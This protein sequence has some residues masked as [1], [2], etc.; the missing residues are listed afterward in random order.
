[1]MTVCVTVTVTMLTH[2]L[3]ARDTCNGCYDCY[4]DFLFLTSSTLQS[5]A[6]TFVLLLPTAPYLGV[7]SPLQPV[8]STSAI[9]KCYRSVEVVTILTLCSQFDNSLV[10]ESGFEIPPSII[11]LLLKKLDQ[12]LKFPPGFWIFHHPI[13]QCITLFSFFLIINCY[14]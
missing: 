10:Q 14:I 11:T 1:M 3:P 6:L 7:F 4:D 9:L 12:L 13:E 8:P 5:P 2:P